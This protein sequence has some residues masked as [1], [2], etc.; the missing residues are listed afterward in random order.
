MGDKAVDNLYPEWNMWTQFVSND[1][2]AGL[3]LDGLRNSHSIEV[4]VTNPAQ[5]RELFDA[6]SY[7]KGG[8]TLRMLEEFLGQ[9]TFRKGLQIYISNNQ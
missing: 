1:T 3:G 6:I 2:N 9:E 8:A 7:S 5:I 4:E